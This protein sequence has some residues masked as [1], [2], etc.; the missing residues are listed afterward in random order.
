MTQFRSIIDTHNENK[1]QLI[2]DLIEF[3]NKLET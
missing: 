2:F 1:K 3:I